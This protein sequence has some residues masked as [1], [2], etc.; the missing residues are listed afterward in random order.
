VLQ[1][2]ARVHGLQLL[3]DGVYNADP[4]P[5]NV[6][7]LEDGRTL[8]LLNYGMVGRV[9]SRDRETI[10]RTVLALACHNKTATA[11]QYR[12]SG[13]EVSSS[14]YA[15]NVTQSDAV[16]HRFA[17]FHLDKIDLSPIYVDGST[18]TV[19]M[20]ELLRSL[21]EATVPVWV[22]EARRLGDVLL[23]GVSVQAGPAIH[24][25]V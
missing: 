18:P 7:V 25:R 15:V 2:L 20:L 3:K 12:P 21:R 14:V 23:M 17:T 22:V 16:L 24:R 5:G 4:H 8:G 9:S 1:T 6:L 13:Y 19:G 10:S 11:H